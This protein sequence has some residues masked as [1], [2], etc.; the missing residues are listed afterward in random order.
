LN[1]RQRQPR[2]QCPAFL[3][4]VRRKPCCA[5]G[6][7]PPSQA[8]HIRFG[9]LEIGKRPTGI[10][11][12]P[13]DRWAVPLC[14]DCHLDTP[15]AQHNVGE[16]KFWVRV[17]IDPFALA[18]K[19]Y[20]QFERR[21]ARSPEQRERVVSRA[22]RKTR[23]LKKIAGKPVDLLSVIAAPKRNFTFPINKSKPKRKWPSRPFP[24]GRGFNRR[25]P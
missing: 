22:R 3:A 15:G 13:S 7:P 16:K 23:F 2:I 8:A 25:A 24:K 18:S 11:E 21:A 4:F 17:G 12:K 5:C 1:I 14:A 19:L 20:G 6:A 9:N 10:A